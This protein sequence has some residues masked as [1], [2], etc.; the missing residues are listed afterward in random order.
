[1]SLRLEFSS[2]MDINQKAQI[3]IFIGK[4]AS[5]DAQVIIR[6]NT[7]EKFDA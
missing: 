5:S 2:F 3:K 4:I 6:E 7:T 1:M